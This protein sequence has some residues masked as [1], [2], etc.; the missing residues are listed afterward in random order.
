MLVGE[1][2]KQSPVGGLATRPGIERRRLV[3]CRRRWDIVLS[4]DRPVRDPSGH[5]HSFRHI[6]TSTSKKPFQ[7]LSQ[8]AQKPDKWISV[9]DTGIPEDFGRQITHR[10]IKHL[11]AH[12]DRTRKG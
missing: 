5:R 2:T 12:A 9:P 1:L 7:C 11:V 4:I 8:V 6:A 10:L 3:Q